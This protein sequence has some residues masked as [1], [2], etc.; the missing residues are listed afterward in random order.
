M[1]S[2]PVI[3]RVFRNFVPNISFG[4]PVI[5]CLREH[6]PEAYLDVHLMTKSPDMWLEPLAKARVNSAT[7]HWESVGSDAASALELAQKFKSAGLR[8]GLAIKPK[9]PVEDILPVLHAFDL[10]LIMTVEPGFGGQSF[11]VDMM[12]KVSRA[13]KLYPKLNIQVN[14]SY[15]V[16]GLFTLDSA[17]Y[18]QDLTRS[19]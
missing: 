19:S 5:A 15:T 13:R 12:E 8:A 17:S 7:F 10:L 9:T 14:K 11:M 16:S 18:G 1:S 3:F 6:I 4:P 2:V